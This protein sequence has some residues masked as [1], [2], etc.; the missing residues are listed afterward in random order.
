MMVG[1]FVGDGLN[2]AQFRPTMLDGWRPQNKQ[3]EAL[4]G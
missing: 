2:P 1:D 4:I 3:T